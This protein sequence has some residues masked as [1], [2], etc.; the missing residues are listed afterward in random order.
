MNSD[1]SSYVNVKLSA[2]GTKSDKLGAFS[3]YIKN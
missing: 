2:D 1:N 3:S